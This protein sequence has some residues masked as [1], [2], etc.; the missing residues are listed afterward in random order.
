MNGEFI[1]RFIPTIGMDLQEKMVVSKKETLFLWMFLLELRVLGGVLG[2]TSLAWNFI[3][4]QFVRNYFAIDFVM[5][6]MLQGK[7]L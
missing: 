5:K 4:L 6:V 7:D 3:S 2:C 1:S